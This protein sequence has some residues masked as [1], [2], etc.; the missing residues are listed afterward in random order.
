MENEM[1]LLI[2]LLLLC[3]LIEQQIVYM[4]I[5]KKQLIYHRISVIIK[6]NYIIFLQIY[7][8]Y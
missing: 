2:L 4:I 1:Y 5:L 3:D 7:Q 6:E 8:N